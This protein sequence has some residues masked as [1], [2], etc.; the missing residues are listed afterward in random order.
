[1]ARKLLTGAGIV[2]NWTSVAGAIHGVLRY[3]GIAV[4]QPTVMGVSG[5][6]F[7]LAI[8]ESEAGIASSLSPFLF[9]LERA[10]RL[11]SGLGLAWE[12]EVLLPGEV[13]YQR[14]RKRVIDRIRRSIDHKRPAAVFGLHLGEFGIVNGYDDRA[15]VLYVSTSLSSQYGT[16][17]PLE[18]WPAPG[19]PELIEALIP[20]RVHGVDA[21][22]ADRAAIDFAVAYAEQG[23][24]GGPSGVLHGF[25]AYDRWLEAYERQLPLDA[26]GNARTI[27]ILQAARLDA[28]A[29]LRAVALRHA[30]VGSKLTQAADAYRSEALELSSLS[31]LFPY[32]AGG[33]TDNSGLVAAAAGS[34]RRGFACER[35]AIRNL[36]EALSAMPAH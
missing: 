1:M 26:A 19:R 15:A 3:L 28:A 2:E 24:A 16:S 6:A 9:D 21:L 12:T 27:Q 22:A 14:L 13:E 18:Q 25:A 23:D 7:R 29:Y 5:H 34:V 4:D 17:L 30:N 8:A 11:Y 10:S 35:D 20:G 33:D 36:K 32:P 31:T